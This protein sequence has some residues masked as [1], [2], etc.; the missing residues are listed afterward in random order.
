MLPIALNNPINHIQHG[1]NQPANDFG[2]SIQFRP[3]DFVV[4][5]NASLLLRFNGPGSSAGGHVFFRPDL[6]TKSASGSCCGYAEAGAVPRGINTASMIATRMSAG[7]S[8]TK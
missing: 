7:T 8:P 4:T 2:C 5:L 3:S 6:R 1:H